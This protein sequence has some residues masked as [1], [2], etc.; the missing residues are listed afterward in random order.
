MVKSGTNLSLAVNGTQL[1]TIQTIGT[2]SYTGVDSLKLGGDGYNNSCGSAW[3][4]LGAKITT[5]ALSLLETPASPIFQ[6]F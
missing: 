1:G 2:I 3:S 6:W 5:V 4:L